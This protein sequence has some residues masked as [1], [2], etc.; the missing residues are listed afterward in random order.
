MIYLDYNATAPTHPDVI[1]AVNE[2]Y[3]YPFNASSVHGYGRKALAVLERTRE[4]LAKSL[5]KNLSGD[6]SVHVIFT[7][8]GTEANNLAIKGLPEIQNIFVSEVEHPSV[9]RPAE[10]NNGRT[11]NV[12]SN[13]LLD[14]EHL[15]KLLAVAE[16]TSLVSIM[17]VNN[18]N[19][20]IQPIKE[21]AAIVQKYDAYLHVDAVQAFGKIPVDVTDLGADMLTISAH[22]IGGVQGAA[23]LVARKKLHFTALTQGGG[24]E[25]G[26]RSGTENVAAINGFHAII[27]KLPELL[28]NNLSELRD[29]LEQE[30]QKIR[31]DVIIIGQDVPRVGNTSNIITPNLNSETALI[32]F[33]MND[34]AISAGSACSSGKVSFSHVL[35]AMDYADDLARCALRVSLGYQTTQEDIDRFLDCYRGL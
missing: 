8:S 13:G 27:N 19:G 2:M 29:Y 32:N 21:V 12:H 25:S 4:A 3:K 30:V 1:D 14:L 33:D 26:Y 6:D 17:L 20:I 34:I 15:D 10:E 24:Q 28:Q 9:L 5:G 18:E 16:G 31:P 11:I 35:S 22:K 23:A 7:S